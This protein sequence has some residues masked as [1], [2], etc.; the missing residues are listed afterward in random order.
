MALAERTDAEL[1]RAAG[2]GDRESFAAFYDRHAGAVFGYCRRIVDD[3][4]DAADAAQEAFLGLLTRE[5]EAPGSIAEPAAYLFRAARN[6]ALRI[7]SRRQRQRP[8]EQL[9]ELAAVAVLAE[10]EERVLT[11]DLQASVRAANGRLPVRQR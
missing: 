3:E 9:P 8:V 7:V 1:L 4:H 10:P 5:H 2:S 11:A 6:A